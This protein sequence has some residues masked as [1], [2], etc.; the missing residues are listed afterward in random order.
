MATIEIGVSRSPYAYNDADRG[1]ADFNDP[2]PTEVTVSARVLNSG[3]ASGTAVLSLYDL[4][5]GGPEDGVGPSWSDSVTI[6]GM[7][8]DEGNPT[9]GD[10]KKVIN[11]PPNVVVD[12]LAEITDGDGNLLE[13]RA[14]T[15]N[16][17]IIPA[18]PIL[19][20]GDIDVRV[21]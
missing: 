10:L 12:F 13:S 3:N 7:S 1:R 9:P 15:V 2:H 11:L 16:P 18:A 6:G 5:K 4:A 20:A 14:F 17:Y 19:S 8:G 21:R